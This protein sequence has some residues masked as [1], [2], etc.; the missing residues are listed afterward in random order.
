MT[1]RKQPKHRD[2]SP[3]KPATQQDKANRTYIRGEATPI[4]MRR[5]YVSKSI[6]SSVEPHQL[7]RNSKKW[8]AAPG[9][10]RFSNGPKQLKPDQVWKKWCPIKGDYVYAASCPKGAK[11]WVKA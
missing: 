10:A 8:K 6:G 4:T 9:S 2:A 7:P 5:P 11:G 1:P 3:C